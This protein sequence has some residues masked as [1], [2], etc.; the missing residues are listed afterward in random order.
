VYELEHA[1]GR[2]REDIGKIYGRYRGVIGEI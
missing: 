2:Y 1:V